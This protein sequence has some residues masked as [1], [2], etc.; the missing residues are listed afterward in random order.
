M[1]SLGPSVFT[2]ISDSISRISFSPVYSLFLVASSLSLARLCC[3]RTTYILPACPFLPSSFLLAFSNDHSPVHPV[4]RSSCHSIASASLF[5]TLSPRLHLHS[6]DVS[7]S[8]LMVCRDLFLPHP[9]ASTPLSRPLSNAYTG[10]RM[11]R[12]DRGSRWKV[13]LPIHG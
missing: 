10:K 6:L 5:S 2:A 3:V 7:P 13:P 9:S 4:A 1:L 11:E 8:L 12:N